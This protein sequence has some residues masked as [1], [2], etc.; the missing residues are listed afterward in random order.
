MRV[1]PMARWHAFGYALPRGIVILLVVPVLMLFFLQLPKAIM[2]DQ[3]V[4]PCKLQTSPNDT[5]CVPFHRSMFP[6]N[7]VFGTATAA[8]QARIVL[9][10]LSESAI[11]R[12]VSCSL[13]CCVG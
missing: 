13:D 1:E 7:F 3:F 4:M 8:F 6:A 2:P 5:A 10:Q 9:S 12:S 11:D